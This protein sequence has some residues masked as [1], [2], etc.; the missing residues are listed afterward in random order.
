MSELKGICVLGSTGSIGTQTLSIVDN[1]PDKFRVVALTAGRNIELLTEQIKKFRP[2]YV[3]VQSEEDLSKVRDQFPELEVGVGEAGLKTAV[4]GDGIHTVV[5]G[6][7]GFAALTPTIEAIRLK[8]N[9]ALANKE[10]LVVAGSLLKKEI[11][12]S[13]A[14]VI[15]VDSEHNALFQLL[16]GRDRSHVSTLVLTASGGPLLRRPEIPLNDVTPAIA[17]KH[18]NW[19]MGPKISVDSATLMNKGLELIE[20]HYLFDVPSVRIEVWVHPQSIIHGAVWLT[21]NTCLAQLSLPNMKS[22]IGFA[23]HYPE[24]LPQVIPKL[25]LKEMSQ[26]EFLPPDEQR[27]RCLGLA[28]EALDSGPSHLVVLNASNEIA[29]ARFLEGS[30]LFSEIPA[31]IGSLLEKHASIPINDLETVYDLDRQSRESAKKWRALN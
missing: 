25:S 17:V 19:K 8:R 13:G 12:R 14:R 11:A 26:L 7:V 29:V 3:C 16:E 2:Q 22:A 20:T 31:L 30:L 10:T 15:P 1:F 27:F 6:V 4:Q 21:D 18:P 28:R 24:R 9:I 23:M 5:V